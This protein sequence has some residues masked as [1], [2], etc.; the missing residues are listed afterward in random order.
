MAVALPALLVGGVSLAGPAPEGGDQAEAPTG[1]DQT[2]DLG[3][4]RGNQQRL[5][6][7]MASLGQM[8]EA[9]KA[10]GDAALAG[11]LQDKVTRGKDIM[12]TATAEIM[13]LRD[14]SASAQ[15]KSFAAEKLQAAADAMDNVMS[16]A[17]G[18][19]GEQELESEDDITRNELDRTEQIP[20]QD[21]TIAPTEPDVPPAVDE[22][23]PPTVASPSI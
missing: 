19:S 7:S 23:Q 8:A 17:K 3:S 22:G 4:V 20:L 11:C 2:I 15:A 10:D 1:N 9:A 21:P 18:C 13:V 16:S 14:A 6:S 12:A 5:E